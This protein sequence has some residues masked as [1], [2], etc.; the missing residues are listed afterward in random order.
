[1]KPTKR[2]IKIIKINLV[3]IVL[4]ILAFTIGLNLIGKLFLSGDTIEVTQKKT[5]VSLDEF[6]SG[7]HNNLYTKITLK[8]STDLAGYIPVSGT[9]S[10]SMSLMSLQKNIE[11]KHFDLLETKK[12]LDTSL[13]DMGISLTGDVIIDVEYE[14]ESFL[15]SLFLNTVLPILLLVLLFTVG[16]RIFSGK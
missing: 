11:I 16:M 10:S 15:T 12:P 6:L 9:T 4:G 3:R 2:P 7:Y 5:E 1:M 8:N 14:K 13:T